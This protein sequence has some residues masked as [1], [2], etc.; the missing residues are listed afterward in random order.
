MSSSATDP[1]F[2]T[3]DDKRHWRTCPLVKETGECACAHPDADPERHWADCEYSRGISKICSCSAVGQLKPE[4]VDHPDHYG[5][6]DN[7]YEV[8]KVIE[9]WELDFC[10]GNTVKY[11]ARAGR[12]DSTKTIEDLKKAR[13]YLDRRIQQLAADGSATSL[14]R[15]DH[16]HE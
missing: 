9:A 1:L 14:T 11:I 12:K 15:G 4:T 8:I 2:V 3:K 6:A 7:P 5:G 13:W 16:T 10:L